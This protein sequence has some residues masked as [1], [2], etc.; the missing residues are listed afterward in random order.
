MVDIASIS[1]AL[2]GIKTATDIAKLIKDSDISLEKA[3]S[4]LKLAEL[5]SAL[6][7]VK[8]EIAEIKQL[9]MNK[10]EELK[11][12]REQLSVR[13]EQLL[14][15]PPYYWR[16][17]K[18]KKDGPFCQQCYDASHQLIRLQ[19]NGSG[20]WECMTCKNGYKD[21]DYESGMSAVTRRI[22]YDPYSNY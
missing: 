22:N 7:D 13:Q 21:K 17:E 12:I 1:S 3:E 5:I 4:K 6:A 2:S 18:D 11:T 15:E 19:G 8:V 20:Y 16:H 14:W 9:L 10:E